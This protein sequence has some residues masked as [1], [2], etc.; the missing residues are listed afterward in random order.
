M[1]IG[2]VSVPFE[3]RHVIPPQ[4]RSDHVHFTRHHRLRPQHQVRHHNPVFHH[5]TASLEHPLPQAAQVELSL[6]QHLARGPV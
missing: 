6:P 1:W 3:R 2:K 4:L 5:V